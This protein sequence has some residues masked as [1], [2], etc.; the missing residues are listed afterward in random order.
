MG[1]AGRS[2]ARAAWFAAAGRDVP[3]AIRMDV[4]HAAAIRCR[5]PSEWAGGVTHG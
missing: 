3:T 1:D 5:V 2:I 4:D